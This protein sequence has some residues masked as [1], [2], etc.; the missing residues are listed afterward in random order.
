VEVTP[1]NVRLRKTIL[2][3]TTRLKANRN[4]KREAAPR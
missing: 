1:H 4:K 3:Q 2:D